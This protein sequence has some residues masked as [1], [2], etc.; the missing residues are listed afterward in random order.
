[1]EQKDW[2][3]SSIIRLATNRH[4]RLITAKEELEESE[5]HYLEEEGFRQEADYKMHRTT[6]IRVG[7]KYV[8]Q[9]CELRKMVADWADEVLDEVGPWKDEEYERTL[10]ELPG[11]REIHEKTLNLVRETIEKLMENRGS[12]IDEDTQEAEPEGGIEEELLYLPE[13]W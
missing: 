3:K 11:N 1:M 5:L 10:R 12:L 7:L 6:A 8:A 9:V 4:L 13:G 2:Q